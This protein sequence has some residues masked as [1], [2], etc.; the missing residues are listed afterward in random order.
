VFA[1]QLCR[2][3]ANRAAARLTG[4]PILRATILVYAL[5]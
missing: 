3:G 2:I 4:L 5:G 1:R